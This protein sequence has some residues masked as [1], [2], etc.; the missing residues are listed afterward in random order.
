[1]WA[2]SERGVIVDYKTLQ[3]VVDEVRGEVVDRSFT[4]EK[5][6]AL[7]VE[8][9]VQDNAVQAGLIPVGSLR[10]YIDDVFECKAGDRIAYDGKEYEVSSISKIPQAKVYALIAQ[11]VNQGV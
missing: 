5:R 3:T 7:I 2:I 8:L 11:E 4:L 1:M 10:V 9:G 6:P